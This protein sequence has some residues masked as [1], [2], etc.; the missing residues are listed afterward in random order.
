MHAKLELRNSVLNKTM[1]ANRRCN[2]ALVAEQKSGRD[3]HAPSF[4]PAA[5]AYFRRST[6]RNAKV[7]RQIEPGS[8]GFLVAMKR[9]LAIGRAETRRKTGKGFTLIE[10]LVVIA[11][12]A[13]LASRQ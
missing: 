8:L 1:K 7:H 5:V 2:L 12:I 13:I 6:E 11:I 9:K 10:L 4:V 3:V